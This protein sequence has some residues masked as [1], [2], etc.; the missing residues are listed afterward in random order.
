MKLVFSV[1]LFVKKQVQS[2]QKIATYDYKTVTR[3]KF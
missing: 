3:N 1:R 2:V